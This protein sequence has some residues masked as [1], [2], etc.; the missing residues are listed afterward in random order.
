MDEKT[1]QSKLYDRLEINPTDYAIE[2]FT[3]VF[4]EGQKH[5]IVPLNAIYQ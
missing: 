2:T 3:P 1:K 5:K 4:K